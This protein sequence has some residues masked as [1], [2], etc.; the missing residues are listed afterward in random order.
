MYCPLCRTENDDSNNYCY[1]DG[2]PLHTDIGRLEKQATATEDFCPSC[3]NKNRT[4]S[5][6]C[7]KCGTN[8]VNISATKKVAP[9]K[10]KATSISLPKVAVGEKDIRQSAITGLIAAGIGVVL[11]LILSFGVMTY[12][13]DFIVKEAAE[14]GV[15]LNTQMLRDGSIIKM[16]VEEDLMVEEGEFELNLSKIYGV[17][18]MVTLLNGVDLQATVDYSDDMYDY[19]GAEKISLKV[20]NNFVVGMI[21]MVIAL[22]GIGLYIGIRARKYKESI[23]APLVVGISVYG[24]F[25]MICAWS[26]KIDLMLNSRI[27]KDMWFNATVSFGAFSSLFQTLFIGLIVTGLVALFTKYGKTTI[28]VVRSLPVL[29]RYSIFSAIIYSVVFVSLAVYS[30]IYLTA[31]ILPAYADEEWAIKL[32]AINA[33]PQIMHLAHLST[34]HI[35][36]F[37]SFVQLGRGTFSVFTSKNDFIGID[38]EPLS[39]KARAEMF[40]SLTGSAWYMPKFTFLL[41]LAA[42]IFAGYA[43][44]RNLKVNIKD[45]A[46]FAGIYAGVLA[47]ASLFNKFSVL[48]N[49]ETG[50][51]I[52]VSFISALVFPFILAVIG[53]AIGAFIREK[54]TS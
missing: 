5:A 20:T 25:V 16:A 48:L 36:I 9:A 40:Y 33:L 4:S 50:A 14:D 15:R 3:G 18:T 46:I 51:I 7:N 26:A 22:A 23:I 39:V 52:E 45:I 11:M 53:L 1:A 31:N 13:E 21:A 27:L 34:I 54:R 12:V 19:I 2:Y 10:V 30:Y 29:Q 49:E 8:A 28:Q 43:L 47:I 17:T 41:P 37:E 35:D 32:L 6:Y 24:V 38:M 42:F 44:F